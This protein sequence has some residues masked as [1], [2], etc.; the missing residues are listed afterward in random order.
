MAI[1]IALTNNLQILELNGAPPTR[2]GTVR[3]EVMKGLRGDAIAVGAVAPLYAAEVGLVARPQPSEAE[4]SRFQLRVPE[5]PEVRLME[6]GALILAEVRG[7]V[8]KGDFGRL[9]KLCWW[10]PFA[11]R[12]GEVQALLD[13]LPR[14]QAEQVAGKRRGPGRPQEPMEQIGLI[15][16]MDALVR[17][18]G[19]TLAEA[20][21]RIVKAAKLNLTP[22]RLESLHAD[23][24]ALVRCLE[25]YCIPASEV[26]YKGWR[27]SDEDELPVYV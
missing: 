10:F 8:E 3:R 26:S 17:E 25:G 12:M 5:T 18:K 16:T 9:R 27:E 7:A 11:H 19:I 15:V 21:R 6:N 13:S 20:A 4:T 14:R 22:H 23:L 1:V 24:G 2:L